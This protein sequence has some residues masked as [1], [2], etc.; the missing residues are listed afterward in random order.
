MALDQQNIV[1]AE[2][3]DVYD[4]AGG[5][6]TLFGDSD[7]VSCHSRLHPAIRPAGR[8]KSEVNERKATLNGES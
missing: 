3:Q 6:F 2:S 1:N 8:P 4:Q 5:T 7:R